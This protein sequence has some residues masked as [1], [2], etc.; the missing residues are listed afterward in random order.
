M[1]SVIG[2]RNLAMALAIGAGVLAARPVPAAEPP[3]APLKVVASMSVLGDMVRQ[4]GGGAVDVVTLV[5]PDADTH[6]FEPTPANA[7][8]LK[9]AGLVVMNGLGLEPWLPRLMKATG[10]RA[11]SVTVS[12]G[13]KPRRA[14]GH[15]HDR[16]QDQ[17]HNQDHSQDHDHEQHHDRGHARGA[18]DPHAWQDVANAMIYARN[19]AA[20]LC[21]ADSPRCPD[22]RA[23]GDALVHDLESLDREV[24]E[25]FAPVPRAERKIITT[26]DAFGYYGAAYGLTL[27]APEGMST[28]AEPTARSV[29]AL[30]RQI[31]REKITAIFVENVTDSRL[32]ERI[33][34]ESQAVVGGRLYSDALSAADG[35]AASYQRMIRHNTRMIVAALA[36]AQRNGQ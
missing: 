25:A 13:V 6:M 15:S 31:R 30:I 10:T 28:E 3:K 19:I 24:K 1:A 5:G 27:L 32:I 7:R 36:G 8:D 20:A 16:D 29:A 12:E 22:Y 17:D 14:G 4:V 26:H 2:L 9:D 21:Q 18:V 34:R 23:G 33:A 11:A 35:P